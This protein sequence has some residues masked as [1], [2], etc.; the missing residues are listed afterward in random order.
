MT[1]WAFGYTLKERHVKMSF[2][3]WIFSKIYTAIVG[4]FVRPF[5]IKLLSHTQ[6]LHDQRSFHH[7][8]ELKQ[9]IIKTCLNLSSI[10][11]KWWPKTKI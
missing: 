2:M 3:F 7:A 4:W 6:T 11:D 10:T 8:Q 9:T 1:I 5:M